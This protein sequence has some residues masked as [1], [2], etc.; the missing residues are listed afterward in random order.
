MSL[1]EVNHLRTEFETGGNWQEAVSD[2]SFDLAGGEALGLVGESGC[3]KSTVAFSLMRLLP[4]N[5]R[6]AGGRIGFDGKDL[7]DI[8][9]D[10]MRRM[11]GGRIGMMF[12]NPMTA[13]DPAFRIGSQIGETLQTHLDVDRKEA[14]RMALE[15]LRSVAI[16]AAEERLDA[17]PHELSGG[18][19]Q[20]AALAI[21]IACRPR[22]LIADEPTTALDVTIQ[23]QILRLIR[24]LLIEERGA[25]VLLITHDLGVV[26]HT[27]DRVA[28][29][30]AGEIVET[31]T[32][33]SVFANPLHPYTQALLEAAPNARTP[34]GSLATIPGRVPA[35]GMRPSGCRFR[36]RCAFERPDCADPS[37]PPRVRLDKHREVACVLHAA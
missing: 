9:E 28:I 22:L 15:L 16:P 24:T 34:R 14:R 32:V 36:G 37:G 26:A 23:A 25:G 11:R 12:Q 13:L 29:M 21:A 33:A 3:G 4:G 7:A 5:A 6:L 17:Y 18:M 8:G 19:R 2:I 1:L 30:Y 35:L 31:G 10:E 20:R 27:C